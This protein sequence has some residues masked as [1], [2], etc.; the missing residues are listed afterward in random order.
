MVTSPRLLTDF[1][2]IG[3]LASR[4]ATPNVASGEL[5]EWY[6]TTNNQLTLW[7]GS[8]WIIYSPK[9]INAAPTLVQAAAVNAGAS[10]QGA[11][12][13]AAPTNGSLLLAFVVGLVPTAGAGWTI[14]ARSD[15]G[16]STFTFMFYKIAGASESATQNPINAAGNAAIAIFEI[17]S[18]SSPGNYYFTDIA[19]GTTGT[20]TPP[21]FKANGLYVGGA[22]SD[23]SANL[24]T[25]ITGATGGAT[26][27]SGTRS[28]QSFSKASPA[29]ALAGNA[30]QATWGASSN[31]RVVG[32]FVA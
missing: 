16:G 22:F 24:P 17:S 14:E 9:T 32:A 15:N 19:G 20:V 21:A 30:I 10:I 28:V 18:N 1:C 29:L 12:F 4:P 2:G 8:A 7:N 26:S 13:G 6:D 27:A 31:Y 11:T 3:P 23:G 25:S 5:S